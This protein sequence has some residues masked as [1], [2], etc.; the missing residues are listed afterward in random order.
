MKGGVKIEVDEILVDIKN[1]LES[2]PR[3][4]GVTF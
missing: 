2:E 1:S 3:I 4:E